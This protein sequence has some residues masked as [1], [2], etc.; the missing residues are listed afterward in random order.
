MKK[1]RTLIVDDEPIA[2]EILETYL[3]KIPELELAG[4]CKNALEAFSMLNKGQTDLM[5]LDIN[6]PEISGIDF[7]KSLKNPPHIIFTTAYSEFALESYEMNAIDYLLKPISFERFLK[8][9]DKTVKIIQA[10]QTENNAPVNISTQSSESQSNLMFVKSEGKLIKIDLNQ[11]W[12]V[13]GLKDY[14]QLWIDEGKIIV[15]TTMKNLED[16]LLS[17]P[18]FIRVH[19]SHIINIRYISEV[20]GNSI[21]IKNQTITI[22]MTYKD[23]VNR[24]L[25]G[26]KLM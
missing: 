22:G 17:H 1:I 18:H 19:K 26:Y 24:V 10:G 2:Q 14:V 20:W 16:L 23:D 13:E 9:I 4:K 11:L 8:A 5:L 3:L 12:L 6:M 7:L 25:D 21:K 15:H